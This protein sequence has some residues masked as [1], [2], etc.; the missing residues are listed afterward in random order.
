M[1][2]ESCKNKC[3]ADDEAIKCCSSQFLK[4]VFET[5]DGTISQSNKE[6]WQFNERKENKKK[7]LFK[8][9]IGFPQAGSDLSLFF[10]RNFK[11]HVLYNSMDACVFNIFLSNLYVT[12]IQ[13]AAA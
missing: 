6:F 3:V 8:G 7:L 2:Q 4:T 13:I 9:N 11:V 10:P 12:V 1:S 5:A